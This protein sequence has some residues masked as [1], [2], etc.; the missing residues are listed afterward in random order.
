MD[1]FPRPGFCYATSNTAVDRSG[2][3]SSWHWPF[4]SS[5]KNLWSYPK[6]KGTGGII[7]HINFLKKCQTRYWNSKWYISQIDVKIC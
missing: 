7:A 5:E 2:F 4:R 6:H 1:Q 3:G